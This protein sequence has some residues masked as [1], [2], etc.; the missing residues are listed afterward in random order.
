[1]QLRCLCRYELTGT[2]DIKIEWKRE[3]GDGVVRDTHSH[4]D[5]HVCYDGDDDGEW[6]EWVLLD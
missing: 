1:M 4:D 6:D 5:F 2:T 3:W